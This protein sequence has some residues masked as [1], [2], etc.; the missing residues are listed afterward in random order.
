[1]NP[2]TQTEP[3]SK[4]DLL[5]WLVIAGLIAAGIW[6]NFHFSAIAWPLRLI[7]WILLVCVLIAIT[8]QTLKG[9][10]AWSFAKAARHELRKVVWPTRQETVQ[11]TMLVVALV[12]VMAM[13]MWGID[14]VLLWAVGI[15]TK[16][17]GG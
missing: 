13:F 10:M 15:L 7:G 1:M 12:I 2:I 11:M 4:I 3:T 14:S 6:A 9:Q 5:K 8:L 16:Q 17:G